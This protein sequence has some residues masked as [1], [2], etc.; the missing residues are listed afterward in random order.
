VTCCITVKITRNCKFIW[1][2]YTTTTKCYLIEYW[3]V[4][5]RTS[6][7]ILIYS[8]SLGCWRILLHLIAVGDAHLGRIPLEEGSARRWDFC[9]TT[10]IY[11]RHVHVPGE[12]R[13]HNASK[14]AAAEPHIRPPGHRGRQVKTTQVNKWISCRWVYFTY[15]V[16]VRNTYVRVRVRPGFYVTQILSLHLHT[17]TFVGLLLP[18]CVVVGPG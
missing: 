2:S 6:Y 9:L 17:F 15:G 12:V 14:R 10:H 11:K 5:I 4:D 16:V 18:A 8:A 13:T 7:L 3:L 1:G